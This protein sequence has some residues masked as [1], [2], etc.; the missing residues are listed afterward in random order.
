VRID[1]RHGARH[2]AVLR[3]GSSRCGSLAAVADLP[4]IIR[5]AAPEDGT[6]MADMLVEATNWSPEWKKKSR[7]R[8]LSAAGTAHYIAGWPRHTDLGVIAE[9]SGERIGAAWLRFL[10][11]ADPGYGFVA[12]D[13]PELTVGV[14]VLWRGRGVGRALLQAI[15]EQARSAGIRQISLSVERKNFAQK[16]YISEGYQIVD[17]S[18][19]ASDTMVK[20]LAAGRVQS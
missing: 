5:R 18:D 19:A 10:P 9:A 12:A 3:D 1:A 4:W 20:D 16:L 13:I 14:A 7:K 8:V 17:S 6:F 2:P 11:A 15:A